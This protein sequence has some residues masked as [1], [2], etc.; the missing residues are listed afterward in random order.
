MNTEKNKKLGDLWK[1]H[2]FGHGIHYKEKLFF[3]DLIKE[4]KK[5]Y[6]KVLDIGIGDGRVPNNIRKY[7]DAEF[8]GVDLNY[9]EFNDINFQVADTRNL[10]FPD[11]YFDV[12]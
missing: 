12:V 2:K 8:Y 10:P 1:D 4:L 11:N 5:K 7:V 3:F 9:Y 6:C